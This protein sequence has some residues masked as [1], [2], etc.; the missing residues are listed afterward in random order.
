MTREKK[1]EFTLRISQANKTEL[2]IILYDIA[3]SYLSDAIDSYNADNIDEAKADGIKAVACIE[4]MQK[5]LHFEYDLAKKLQ[6]LYLFMK[7]ELRAG[8]ISGDFSGYGQVKKE[9]EK[10]M[11]SYEAIKDTDTSGPVMVHTQAVLSGMTYSKDRL[12]DS[13][14]T[15]CP[16]RGY[17]V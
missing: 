12:L 3:I 7:K 14:T 13:L 5:N 2:I 17:R 8:I 6:Q 4:E 9:L 10:L 15:D 11:A 1:N 16:S